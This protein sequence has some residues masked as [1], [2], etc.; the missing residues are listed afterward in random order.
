[1]SA[2]VEVEVTAERRARRPSASPILL[3]LCEFL[4]AVVFVCAAFGHFIAPRDPLAQ[5]LT[6]SVTPP[7]R[8]HLLGTDQ[9]GED[10]LSRVIVGTRTAIV[11]P[12]LIALGSMLI[13]GTLGLLSG[14][15]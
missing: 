14:Y 7:S 3:G 8:A 10:V 1:M 12:A 15:F 9:L 11:G 6:A 2:A 4:L 5:D 13:G